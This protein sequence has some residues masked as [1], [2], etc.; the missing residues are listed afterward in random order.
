MDL[1]APEIGIFVSISLLLAAGL[2]ALVTD[3]LKGNMEHLR[4]EN[5]RLRS[6]EDGVKDLLSIPGI[7]VHTAD[8][9]TSAPPEAEPQAPDNSGPAPSAS[10]L[11][12]KSPVRPGPTVRESPMPVEPP[13]PNPHYSR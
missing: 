12:A 6:R 8:G 5:V 4:E 7:S 2:I 3:L 9:A 11:P 13:A 10:P 1:G